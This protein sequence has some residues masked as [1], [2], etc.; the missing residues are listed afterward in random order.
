MSEIKFTKMHGT[1]N[2]FIVIDCI[3]QNIGNRNELS[4]E[5]CRRQF[6]VGADQFILI[7]ASDEGDYCMEIYNPDGSNVEMCGNALRAVALYVK[8]YLND[9]RELIKIETLGGMTEAVVHDNLVTVNMGPPSFDASDV[10][11]SQHHPILN[12]EYK[13][14]DTLTRAITC[15]SMGNPHCIQIV[16]NVENCP[17]ESEGPVIENHSLFKNRTNVEFIEIISREEV[18]MRVWERGTGETLACGSGAC[19]VGAALI[20]SNFTERIIKVNLKGGQ[21]TIEWRDSDNCIYMTGP[22]TFVFDGVWQL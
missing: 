13:F 21:L 9:D 12:K 14:S 17:L 3:T 7:C 2:D 1:G 20:K 6:G 18:N 4:K 22:A 11:L 5:M 15:V 10:G 8:K 19:A 16:N